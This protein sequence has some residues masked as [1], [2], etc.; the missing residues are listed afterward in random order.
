MA[1][2]RVLVSVVMPCHNDGKYLPEAVDSLRGDTGVPLEL[3]IVDDGSDDP[4]TLRVIRELSFPRLTRLRTEHAGPAAARNAAI[5]A[6]SGEYI[7]PLDADD[8]IE[9]AYIRRAAEILRTRPEIG[10]V[11]CRAD[12]FG[13]RRGPW[14]LPP[15]SLREELLGNCLFVTSFFRKSGWE[16]VGGF[17]EEFRAGM[18]DY[19]FFL[20]L[21]ELGVGVEQLPETFFHYRIKPSSRSRALAADPDAVRETFR[22]LYERHR[23]LYEEHMGECFPELRTRQLLES[24]QLNA[25]SSDPVLAYWRSVRVLKP[26]KAERMERILCW[27]QKIK[28]MLGR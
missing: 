27:K 11:T 7:L 20:S 22:K 25:W 19:D 24:E 16:R 23:G 13:A 10:I 8:R 9:P 5:R 15:Y 12:F 4:E 26:R 14:E 6:A 21:I 17:S 3:I 18:E 28:K 2:E 1:D